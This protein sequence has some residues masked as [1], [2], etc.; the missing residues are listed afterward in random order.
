MSSGGSS[1]RTV[2]NLRSRAASFSTVFR[3]SSMVVAPII[4]SSPLASW[5]FRMLAASMAPS[6]APTPMMVCTSSIKRITLPA[7]ATSSRIALT[8]SSNSPRYL[9]PATMQVK[10]TETILLY[11]RE[12]GTSPFTII[13]ARPSATAVLPT[14]A[15]PIKQGLFLLRR[16]KICTTRSS[17]RSL[18]ITGSNIF[19][20]AIQVKS[21]L[22]LSSSGVLVA[23]LTAFAMGLFP[24]PIPRL[25]EAS[26]SSRSSPSRVSMRNWYSSSWFTFN[27]FKNRTA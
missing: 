10:S 12:S 20:W 7:L 4:W 19:S 16:D 2:W 13:W 14:P 1:T 15:S 21:L 23:G 24:L 22:N 18:P 25:P 9:V 26:G 6:A 5:G 11:C 8:R 3:Y 17:S 27:S